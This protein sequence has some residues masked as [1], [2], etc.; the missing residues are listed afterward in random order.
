MSAN[1]AILAFHEEV[2]GGRRR[3]KIREAGPPFT[4]D[5]GLRMAQLE[6]ARHARDAHAVNVSSETKE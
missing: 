2:R 5:E 4:R 1:E 3:E 6:N